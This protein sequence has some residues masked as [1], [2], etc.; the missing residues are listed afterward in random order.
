MR[1][2]KMCNAVTACCIQHNICDIHQDEF[3]EEWLEKVDKSSGPSSGVSSLLLSSSTAATVRNALANY[4]LTQ[5][6]I[7]L[8]EVVLSLYSVMYRTC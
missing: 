5:L 3:D 4:F 2:D 8:F 1:I 6:C 7:T